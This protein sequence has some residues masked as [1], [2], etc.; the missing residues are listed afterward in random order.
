MSLFGNVFD[1][2][3]DSVG[4]LFNHP[5]QAAGAALGVP[6]YDPFF[7]GLFNNRPGGALLSPTGNFTSSAWQDMYRNN[8]GD[9]GGLNLFN[10]INSIADKVAPAIAGSFAGPAL[11]AAMGGAG[12]GGA[13]S[14]A[15]T[16]TGAAGEGASGLS[17]ASAAEG[18]GAGG[19]GTDAAVGGQHLY[20]LFGMGSM[21]GAG[22]GS[23]VGT[24]AASSGGITG[25]AN[26][27]TGLL[28]GPAAVGDAGLT[29]TVSGAGSGI[30]GLMGGSG[31][32]D[33]G[34]ALGSSPVGLYSGLLPGGGMSGTTSGALGGG[35]SGQAAGAAPLGSSTMGGFGIS[36]M[37]PNM[38]NQTMQMMQARNQPQQ[39]A[40]VMP[41][42]QNR[43]GGQRMPQ[44][45]IGPSM[46]YAH[47]GQVGA[48]GS[49]VPFGFGGSV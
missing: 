34:S 11:G 5:L 22:L 48:P 29:G 16:A 31:V 39:Q 3:K 26:G 17:A 23:G 45:P 37:N 19:V 30:G 27:L 28:N 25:G 35:I 32:G 18:A 41:G 2:A 33:L 44:M 38:V 43:Y 12:G 36:S 7:G 20:G 9:A 24:S 1:F 40:M 6:G 10:G 13:G 42:G 47:F 14:G 46:S 4:E 8:P 49:G 15:G 21:N